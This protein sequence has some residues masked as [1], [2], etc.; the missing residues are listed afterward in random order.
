MKE[1]AKVQKLN[2]QVRA[3]QAELLRNILH[4]KYELECATQN[5]SYATDP[6]LIDMYSYQIKACQA[7]YHYLLSRAKAGGVTDSGSLLAFSTE[8]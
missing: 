7:K 6:V 1:K 8:R 4:A 2:K 5:F 3:E